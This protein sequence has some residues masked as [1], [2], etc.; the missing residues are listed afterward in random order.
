MTI[1]TM[2]ITTMKI[3]ATSCLSTIAVHTT[4]I[5]IGLFLKMGMKFAKWQSVWITI[6]R[7]GTSKAK[8]VGMSNSK[9]LY[10]ALL[11]HYKAQKDEALAVLE[12]YFNNAVGIGEHSDIL[13]E[14]KQWTS[15]LTEAEEAIDSLQINFQQTPS[16][17]K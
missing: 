13:N 6:H 17:K 16:S 1:T 4:I 12:V 10:K 5:M 2:M 3:T 11:S 15:K 9:S 14:L 7:N 8:N